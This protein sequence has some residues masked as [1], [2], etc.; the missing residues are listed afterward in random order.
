MNA[1]HNDSYVFLNIRFNTEHPRNKGQRYFDDI[2][3]LYIIGSTLEKRTATERGA[4]HMS[5][6]FP[7]YDRLITDR[8]YAGYRGGLHLFEDL[9]GQLMSV[10]L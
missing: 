9:I 6:S 10:K 5:V 1:V 7:T 2:S 8:G 3:P 4:K